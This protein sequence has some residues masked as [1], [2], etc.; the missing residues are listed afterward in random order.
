MPLIGG[1]PRDK[2][3]DERDGAA[4]AIAYI[5][6]AV[7]HDRDRPA[8]HS[9]GDLSRGQKQIA[10]HSDDTDGSPAPQFGIKRFHTDII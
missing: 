7:R 9:H 3:R 10:E 8:E 1:F 2:E 4:S 6:E 5:V